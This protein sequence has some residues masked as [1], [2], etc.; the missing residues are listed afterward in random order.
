MV[1]RS[2]GNWDQ[3]DLRRAFVEGAAWWE[4]HSQGATMWQSDRTIA[5]DEADRRY[6]SQQKDAADQK[7]QC[8]RCGLREPM[9]HRCL[10]CE[11]EFNG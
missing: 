4:F 5:E 11:H 3:N 1:K 7:L 10:N 9:F 2:E 8:P 6:T